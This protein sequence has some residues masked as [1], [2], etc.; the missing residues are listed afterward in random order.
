VVV[1]GVQSRAYEHILLG[2]HGVSENGAHVA[3]AVEDRGKQFWVWDGAEQKHYDNVRVSFHRSWFSPDGARLTYAAREGKDWFAVIGSSEGER[4]DSMNVRPPT[5]TATGRVTYAATRGALH[6]VGLDSSTFAFDQ[7]G[8]MFP[9]NRRVAFSAR[10]GN[11]WHLVVDSIAGPPYDT[12]HYAVDSRD[13]RRIAYGARRDGRQFV[14]VDGVEGAPY[15]SVMH[16]AF[17][18]DGRHVAYSAKRRDKW[19][20]VVDGKESPLYDEIVRWPLADWM[21]RESFSVIAR[22]GREDFRVT[23]PWR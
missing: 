15:D 17:S 22:R 19:I 1:D 2:S 5:Y 3:Y 13:G 6:Y 21:G 11:R 9:T 14:V 23:V 16:L 18:P 10:V 7:V 12:V 4:F 8:W 20:V